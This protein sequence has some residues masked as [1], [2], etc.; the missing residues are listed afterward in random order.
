MSS[1]SVLSFTYRKISRFRNSMQMLLSLSAKYYSLIAM[2]SVC[3]RR[4]E[5]IIFF[6]KTMTKHSEILKHLQDLMRITQTFTI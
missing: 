4:E 2:I 6:T 3:I 1:I 5:R